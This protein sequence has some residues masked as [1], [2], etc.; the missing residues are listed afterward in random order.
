M[1]AIRIEGA[2]LAWGAS[3]D[4][5]VGPGEVGIRVAA[6]AVNRADLL[7]R[8]GTYPPPPGASPILGL[9]CSGT[10]DAV[11]DGVDGFAVGDRVCALLSGGGYAERVSCPAVQVLP[12]P[13]E[14]SLEEAAALPEAV[15]TVWMVLRDEGRLSA[16]ERVL[17]H[18]GASGIGTT[19][20]QVCRAWG[21]P[22]FVTA[23]TPSKVARCV[24][25]GA[26]GGAARSEGPWAD[27]V[28]H[29][30]PDGVDLIVDP[31][32]GETTEIGQEL[33][34]T[35]GRIVVIGLLGGAH[36]RISLA[37]LLMR[38]QRIVGT[39]LRARSTAEKGRIVGGVAREIW[40]AVRSGAIRP[41]IDRVLP[42]AEA[43]R[44]HEAVRS[45]A[46]VGKVVLQVPP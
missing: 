20:I 31:V 32:G 5:T 8:A 11:G 29:W 4:P 41:T 3:P 21:N 45:N 26:D 23:G 2:G 12:V 37:R 44:A 38:R 6:T 40:P 1:N 14:L 15:A 28:R 25:L 18:A 35:G 16:G 30:A 46:T 19:A 13:P 7:Q 24:A 22:S 39:T 17:L 9:E 36:A 34:G 27:A 42:I 10:I 43:D 33:L